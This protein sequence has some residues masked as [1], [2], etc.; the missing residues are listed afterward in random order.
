MLYTNQQTGIPR[1]QINRV[2]SNSTAS[3]KSQHTLH[4]IQIQTLRVSPMNCQYIPDNI[5]LPRKQPVFVLAC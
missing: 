5:L 1:L 4:R 2:T 3:G